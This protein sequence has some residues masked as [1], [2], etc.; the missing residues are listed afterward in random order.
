M[1]SAYSSCLFGILAYSA[2]S[3][4]ELTAAAKVHVHVFFHSLFACTPVTPDEMMV[5]F[6]IVSQLENSI[7][8]SNSTSKHKPPKKKYSPPDRELIANNPGGGAK[9]YLEKT[10]CLMPTN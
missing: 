4:P 10:K 8:R 9:P 7:V 2:L 6:G 3:A 1:K 5:F